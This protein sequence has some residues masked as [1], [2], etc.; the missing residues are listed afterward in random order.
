MKRNFFPLI[1]LPLL[2]CLGSCNNSDTGKTTQ[3][4]AAAAPEV[5]SIFIN[6]DSIHYIDVG[7]GDPVVF[8]H[9]AVGDYRTF[10]KQMEEF[11]KSHRVIAY[12]RRFAYPNQQTINDSARLSAVSHASDLAEL[13]KALKLGPAN[14]YGHSY[15]ADIALLTT[16]DHPK[17]VS[18]LILGEPFI[19][20][21]MQ[22]VPGGDTILNNFI[23]K[24]FVPVVEAFKNNNNEE[25]VKGLVNGVMGDS[26]YYNKLPQKDRDIMMANFHEVKGVLLGKDNFPPVGCD[27]VK[28]IKTP[29]LLLKGDKSPIV[30]S[31]MIDE[32]NRCLSNKEV[33]TLANTSHGLEYEN[34]AEFNKIVLGFIDKQ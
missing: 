21:L 13:L 22:Q 2:F 24:A 25:G 32:L 23:T 30:F 18:S 11:T 34:P 8:V 16:M 19:S 1:F 5:K 3:I 26:L 31:L 20:S 6:G 29:V 28:K 15:G 9:G 33:A 12:S 7:K 17:L 4:E 14:L 10:G 27:D